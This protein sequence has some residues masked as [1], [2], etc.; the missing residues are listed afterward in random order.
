MACD[1][2]DLEADIQRVV[3]RL[4]SSEP[5]CH[6]DFLGLKLPVLCSMPPE[7]RFMVT[8]TAAYEVPTKPPKLG[9]FFIAA[10]TSRAKKHLSASEYNVFPHW[11]Q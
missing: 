5:Q 1:P 2:T 7:F 4:Q 3:R 8:D 11:I 6:C 10:I 9:G